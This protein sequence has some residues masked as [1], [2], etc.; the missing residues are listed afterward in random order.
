MPRPKQRGTGTAA[1]II[2]QLRELRRLREWTTA[3]LAAAM[4]AE[5]FAHWSTSTVAN[6]EN[7]RRANVSTDELLGLALVYGVAPINLLVPIDEPEMAITP[8]ATVSAE[9]ARRWIAG[10][11]PLDPDTY[12]WDR[13]QPVRTGRAAARAVAGGTKK[14]VRRTTATTPEER[15]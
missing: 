1:G 5:G 13:H 2:R 10:D 6:I 7:G 4:Q 15:N 12:W 9:Q 14:V 8:R 3:D 11:E